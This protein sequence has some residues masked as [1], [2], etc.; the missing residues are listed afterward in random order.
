MTVRVKL[1]IKLRLLCFVPI[2][3]GILFR[4]DAYS[5][6][7]FPG[8]ADWR[9]FWELQS[10]IR[11][12]KLIVFFLQHSTK[13]GE[14]DRAEHDRLVL[15]LNDDMHMKWNFAIKVVLGTEHK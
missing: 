13:C 7:I 6:Y 8:H 15:C 9:N 14:H 5:C 1:Q 12:C 10:L 4:G 3:I 11:I 2:S